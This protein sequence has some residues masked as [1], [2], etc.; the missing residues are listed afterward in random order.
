MAVVI[1][2]ILKEAAM[3]GVKAIAGEAIKS[4][5][6]TLL[7][8]VAGVEFVEAIFG[9][10]EMRV[11]N[12]KLDTLVI[13]TRSILSRT[14]DIKE[15]VNESTK[16]DFDKDRRAFLQTIENCNRVIEQAEKSLKASAS[17]T[18]PH[19]EISDQ[20]ARQLLKFLSLTASSSIIIK[21]QA[22]WHTALL[23]PWPSPTSDDGKVQSAQRNDKIT[24]GTI[25][26]ICDDLLI[27]GQSLDEY[28]NIRIMYVG[29][30]CGA[31]VQMA[32][33]LERGHALVQK[34]ASAKHKA[35]LLDLG[36]TPYLGK[37]F[38]ELLTT[39]LLEEI[40]G[41]RPDILNLA[42]IGILREP[43]A[44]PVALVSAHES[45]R[46]LHSH[47]GCWPVSYYFG[48][49]R[50][51][52]FYANVEKPVR[53]DLNEKE[54]EET[55]ENHWWKIHPG[56]SRGNVSI[57]CMDDTTYLGIF[58]FPNLP[59]K[60]H[61]PAPE[62]STSCELSVESA[63]RR[64]FDIC[65]YSEDGR[66]WKIR[67]KKW[68]RKDSIGVQFINTRTNG[69]LEI[70]VTRTS[71][72][73]RQVF[74]SNP[75]TDNLDNE[76]QWWLLKQPKSAPVG[77]PET[78]IPITPVAVLKDNTS[79]VPFALALESAIFGE[80]ADKTVTPDRQAAAVQAA[81]HLLK[82]D[83]LNDF[84]TAPA[85]EAVKLRWEK[86]TQDIAIL[87]RSTP[88]EWTKA[89]HLRP[90]MPTT[91]HVALDRALGILRILAGAQK[92]DSTIAAEALEA[93]DPAG[94]Q[95]LLP[96][97]SNHW[98]SAFGVLPPLGSHGERD[99]GIKRSKKPGALDIYAYELLKKEK[100]QPFDEFAAAMLKYLPMLATVSTAVAAA[101]AAAH[102]Y[103]AENGSPEQKRKMAELG[104][105]PFLTSGA[106]LA[107]YLVGWAVKGLLDNENTV[108][109][110]LYYILVTDGPN[111]G[112]V[113][114]HLDN[115]V[116]TSVSEYRYP[117]TG[118]VVPSKQ[119]KYVGFKPLRVDKVPKD[120]DLS[121]ANRLWQI[122]PYKP[123]LI[124]AVTI[125]PS[126]APNRLLG[127]YNYAVSTFRE[128]FFV[129]SPP[130]TK[131]GS[132]H[133]RWTDEIGIEGPERRRGDPCQLQAND[134]VWEI[135]VKITNKW[136]IFLHNRRTKLN[137]A[138]DFE[139]TQHSGCRAKSAK[140]RELLLS[141]SDRISYFGRLLFPATP[142]PTKNQH[143]SLK[144]PGIS[145]HKT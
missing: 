13:Q 109:A 45:K 76:L 105:S 1:V 120:A 28:I 134:A 93:L 51:K 94:K 142:S 63:K 18:A 55:Q 92:L 83:F 125:A 115:H 102:A 89:K 116:L 10:G 71:V 25:G 74:A 101:L 141:E 35:A 43:K 113:L 106:Q 38:T 16:R 80:S 90:L 62:K 139:T 17:D 69:V 131:S 96:Y 72:K 52:N 144:M 79:K 91:G 104:L 9:G 46:I 77:R 87:S 11:V 36:T 128:S 58:T 99:E 81:D 124:D 84:F 65:E 49:R 133:I 34:H 39:T 98:A 12:E 119:I 26:S 75:V 85:P 30:L 32:D 135:R 103:V 111:R 40:I 112:F 127:V 137:L 129:N 14:D 132:T 23:S 22:L 117:L 42:R 143:W 59:L 107:G 145:A 5:A 31:Y 2:P 33:T 82:P 3:A 7:G 66:D 24:K 54:L 29:I 48:S 118:T 130:I 47:P 70:D 53:G 73:I 110:A 57:T 114:S 121:S 37:A 78:A 138:F 19:L 136:T 126:S 122:R 67:L 123:G 61:V 27:R 41:D 21:G 50:R 15:A 44:L 140:D 56:S 68:P 108:S 64:P 97:L 60:M 95:G 6:K 4:L 20:A 8:E 100:E 86:I 88:D